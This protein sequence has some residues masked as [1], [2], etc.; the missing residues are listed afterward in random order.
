LPVI[1]DR[2]Q[3]AGWAMGRAP[4]QPPCGSPGG[5]KTFR[6]PRAEIDP[7]PH[8]PE[9]GS[10]GRGV[11]PSYQHRKSS[12]KGRPSPSALYDLLVATRI[13]ASPFLGQPP[14]GPLL[15][16]AGGRAGSCLLGHVDPRSGCAG[17]EGGV[18][19]LPRSDAVSCLDAIGD[20]VAAAPPE[21]S[22]YWPR[23]TTSITAWP[24]RR[25]AFGVPDSACRRSRCLGSSIL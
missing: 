21:W 19:M 5:K 1:L 6:A 11:H 2:R 25:P 18:D 4:R 12:R 22:R 15:V 13:S 17:A 24:R 8:Y 3:A 7:A 14:D 16:F 20:P 23:T 9:R 10:A